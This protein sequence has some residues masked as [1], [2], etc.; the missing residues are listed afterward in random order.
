LLDLSQREAQAGANEFAELILREI[1][2]KSKLHEDEVQSAAFAVLKAPDIPSVLFETGFIS[3]SDDEAWLT[4]SA[5]RE[6]ISH[7]AAQAI[8]VYF[9]RR[10]GA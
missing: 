9:A 1:R 3:N 10:S 8:R 6:V 4:S 5:G 2:G 7:S